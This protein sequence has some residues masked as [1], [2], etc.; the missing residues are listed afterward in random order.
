MQ[1]LEVSYEQ[2]RDFGKYTVIGDEYYP[3]DSE[4]R[5]RIEAEPSDRRPKNARV[6]VDMSEDERQQAKTRLQE[7][8]D[9]RRWTSSK[10]GLLTLYKIILQ[11]RLLFLFTVVHVVSGAAY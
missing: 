3:E 2:E 6:G 11:Y 8:R 10:A 1:A 4:K 5:K 7:H 9:K